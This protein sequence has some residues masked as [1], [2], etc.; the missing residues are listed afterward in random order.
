[1]ALGLPPHE[2][3]AGCGGRQR[4][5]NS[6]LCL[7]NLR[8]RSTGLALTS[9]R[10]AEVIQQAHLGVQRIHRTPHLAYSFLRH[11]ALSVA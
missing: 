4:C 7:S 3:P 6:Y 2:G 5:G 8:C 11:T 9:P 1:M 10:L